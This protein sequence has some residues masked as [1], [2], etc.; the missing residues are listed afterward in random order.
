MW[1]IYFGILATAILLPFFCVGL[2]VKQGQ[3]AGG[4]DRYSTQTLKGLAMCLIVACHC[5]GAFGGGITFFTP[6]GG[7]GVA[8]FLLLAA[9]G[10]NESWNKNGC[11]CWW[12]KRLIAVFVP[13]AI[14][15]IC[16]HWLTSD[17]L[18]V[19]FLEDILLIRPRYVYGWYLNYLLVWYILFY[20]VMR[21]PAL[22][23]HKMLL[24]AA[25]T[26]LMFFT[27]D[28]IRA[29]QSL[30]FLAGIILSEYKERRIIKRL[31]GWKTGLILVAVGVVFLAVKQLQIVRQAPA[32]VYHFVQLLIKFPCGLGL[33]FIVPNL[34]RVLNMRFFYYM[35]AVA[36][37]LYLVHG[38]VLRRV[39]VTIPGQLA[40]FVISAALT[41]LLWSTMKGI[42]KIQRRILRMI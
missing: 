37:E 39:P 38:Y 1:I 36:Y 20:G 19:D 7:I 30:S 41:V 3:I 12:R 34:L 35:G 24:F 10:L 28:E 18:L 11:A 42:N 40:F 5:M 32:I 16:F 13:Y 27:Y 6:L 17:F 15:Q 25:I 2:F 26:V 33:C 8:I 31:A 4:L 29:E 9:Y 23:K 22:R 14:V 21:I